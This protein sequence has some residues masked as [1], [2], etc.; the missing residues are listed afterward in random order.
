MSPRNNDLFAAVDALL[1]QAEPLPEPAERERLRTAAGLSRAEVAKALGVSASTVAGWESG[2]SDPAKERRAA[3]GRLLEGLAARYPAPEKPQAGGAE[4][5]SRESSPQAFAGPGNDVREQPAGTSAAPTAAA[6][7]APAADQAG[8][9]APSRRGPSGPRAAARL[10][11]AATAA[12][13]PAA[14]AAFPAG[15]LAVLDGGGTA[16]LA[17]GRTLG[18]PAVTVPGL[19]TWALDAGLGQPRLH[20]HGWDSDPLVVLTPGAAVKLGLP[21]RLADRRGLR[22]AED[23][24]VVREV[25][26][27]GWQLTKRGFGPWARIFRPVDRGGRRQCVQLAVLPWDALDARAWGDTATLPAA[28]VA[29]VLGAYAARV[30]TPRGSTAVTGLELMTAL[31]PPTRPVRTEGGGWTSGPVPGSL[32]A[33][34]D[35]APPEAPDEHPVAQGRPGDQVLDEEA[36][37]WVRD[38]ELLS[39]DECALP[40][41][42]GLDVNA[43]FLAAANRLTVGLGEPVHTDGPRF[44]PK[45]PGCWYVD[46]SHVETDPRLPSPFTPHGRRPAGP[47]WYA[48]PTLAYAAEL[49]HEVRPLEAWLRPEAGPYLDP[50]Y[51][52]LRDA[53]MQ[54]MA[55]L[56]VA[57]GLA[58]PEFL[59]AMERHKA[60][61]PAMAAV[62]SAIK[63]TV[64]G[65]IGKLRERPQ[66]AGYRP[67]ERWP[68]LERPTWRPDI[69]AAVIAQARTNMHRKMLRMA[70][71]GHY[72]VAVLSDCVV[73]PAPGPSPLDV[74]PHDPATGRPL[75]GTF[76]LGVSP[77]MVKHEGTMPFWRCAELLDQ[78]ANP[79]RHIKDT[80]AT[81]GG[82]AR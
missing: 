61:D 74:L 81:D 62:L 32:T 56:G 77:G 21:E 45:L 80:D 20:R 12:P 5:G 40:F 65:G 68:A 11:P 59:A 41:V 72:P 10:R 49:G 48:T 76:R 47:A 30:L 28:G 79:A 2:R 29:R 37:D 60:T 23:H 73:Y 36:Y 33:P 38:S 15:P 13:G 42:V 26:A 50:W 75:P 44:D 9:P 39:D 16:H 35:P 27:A 51:E 64:K 43:A 82:E 67:G 53:Y 34:V 7:A 78:G 8:I 54:T 17:D 31:R 18:C 52:R 1:E 63:A 24:P 66:G 14:D 3:Y 70:A 4:Q 55:D 6:A 22:L 57:K 69:R 25:V 71:A 19:V 58:G 46:L